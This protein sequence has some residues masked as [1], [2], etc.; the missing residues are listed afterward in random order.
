[1]AP[2]GGAMVGVMG[3]I[4]TRSR[5]ICKTGPACIHVDMLTEFGE[6]FVDLAERHYGSVRGL[7]RHLFPKE[8]DTKASQWGKY[9]HGKQRPPFE[10]WNMWADAFHLEGADRQW[11]M[12]LAAIANIP[13]QVRARFV[14]IVQRQKDLKSLALS[15][16][17]LLNQVEV[18]LKRIR[19]E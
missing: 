2:A 1:M 4:F 12:D 18:A 9:A 17:K 19:K 16:E 11:F 15:N 10:L 8:E 14:A 13:V 5:K 6:L 7:A 3:N